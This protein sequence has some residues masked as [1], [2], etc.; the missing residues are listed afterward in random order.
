MTCLGDA[1]ITVIEG[2]GFDLD[3]AVMITQLRKRGGLL[4]LQTVKAIHALYRPL[5]RGSGGSHF[6]VLVLTPSRIMD[7][8]YYIVFYRESL[9]AKKF[10]HMRGVLPLLAV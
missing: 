4:E 1:Q 6:R 8:L 5:R 10:E 3:E 7:L 2:D 9:M